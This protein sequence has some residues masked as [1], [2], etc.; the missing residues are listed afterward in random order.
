MR[1]RLRPLRHWPLA[2]KLAAAVFVLALV[3]Q[4]LVA[5][6]NADE[7]HDQL[8]SRERERLQHRAMEAARRLEERVGRLRAYSELLATNPLIVDAMQD[9]ITRPRGSAADRHR[10]SIERAQGWDARH[11]EVHRLLSSVRQANPWFQ[12]AYLLDPSGLC[13]S[14]SERETQPDMVG[15][16]YDYRPYFRAPVADA[17]PHVTDV[18]KNVHSPGTAIFISAPVMRDGQVAAVVVVKVDTA[19]LDDVV[20][21]LSAR[22]GRNLLVDRF[23]VVVSDAVAGK[24][25]GVDDPASVQFRPLASVDRYRTLFEDTRRYGDPMHENHLDR[26]SDPLGLEGLWQKLR[27]GGTGA[28]AFSFPQVGGDVPEPAMVGYSVVWASPGEPYGY[29]V[30]AQPA[31]QFRG[32]LEELTRTA[33]LR[34][35][36]VASGVAL[37]LGFL[38][39]RMSRRVRRL[40]DATRMVAG[41]ELDLRLDDPY[42]DELGELASSFDRMTQELAATVE[43]VERQRAEADQARVEAERAHAAKHAFISKVGRQFQGPVE[44]IG[45][46]VTRLRTL[47]ET[48]GDPVALEGATA[49][50][51]ANATI[52]RVVE[53]MRT[54]SGGDLEVERVQLHA[55]LAEVT[56]SVRPAAVLSSSKLSLH[57]EGDLGD[58]LVDRAKLRQIVFQLLDNAFKFTRQGEVRVHARRHEEQGIST[59]VVGISDDGIGMTRGQIERFEAEDAPDADAAGTGLVVSKLAARAIGGRLAVQSEPGKGSTFTL[60]LPLAES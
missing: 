17:D 19:A 16:I 4:L 7:V 25:M 5:L 9:R 13:I 3:P 24:S 11:D 52:R 12:H 40:A 20:A 48:N 46:V 31:H 53:Q 54:L 36:L 39:R 33:M 32:P 8:E 26:V 35:V 21:D 51:T 6:V 34:A 15:R 57:V 55:F 59:L 2:L 10:L 47:A 60:T 58:A 28:D 18:L 22:G 23:G 44:Q 27:G 49:I 42:A 30:V 43:S 56:E 29:L 38:I 1:H 14:S 50:E 41:G 37:V 45:V